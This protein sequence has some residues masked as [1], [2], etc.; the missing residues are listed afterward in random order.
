ML[1]IFQQLFNVNG[2]QINQL[3]S[4][5]PNLNDKDADKASQ[6]FQTFLLI[7]DGKIG[8][9][10]DDFVAN[11][12]INTHERLSLNIL[13][14][15]IM[16][17]LQL[18]S[19][20]IPDDIKSQILNNNQYRKASHL[21]KI[22]TQLSK[23]N[24]DKQSTEQQTN[25]INF[26]LHLLFSDLL[27][28]LNKN[29]NTISVYSSLYYLFQL[30]YFFITTSTESNTEMNKEF[31][32]AVNAINNDQEIPLQIAA[33]YGP[34]IA[35]SVIANRYKSKA[36]LDNQIKYYTAEELKTIMQQFVNE[37]K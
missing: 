5:I 14:N 11:I 22:I 2:E 26:I 35:M 18:Q 3:K 16:L 8:L 17:G 31:K 33:K 21:V 7:K 12:D 19:E 24:N 4:V 23:S 25:I 15:A 36:M 27:S 10:N 6:L 28:E 37:I 20:S 34:I 32:D 9:I 29:Q 30:M 1:D 13:S